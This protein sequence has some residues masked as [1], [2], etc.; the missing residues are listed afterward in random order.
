MNRPLPIFFSMNFRIKQ[1]YVS[2]TWHFL[3]LITFMLSLRSE[4]VLYAVL[5]SLFH[6]IGHLASMI[7]LGNAP[8]SVSF[9]LTGINIKR[10]QEVNVSLS[11]E[12]II[13]LAGPFMNLILFL[14]FVLVNFQN[15]SAKALNAASVNL[16]FMTFNLLPVKGLDGGKVLYYS[17]SKFFSYKTANIILMLSSVIFILLMFSY[18]AYVL[19]VTRY[20][21]TMLIIALMLSLSMFS[22][23]EC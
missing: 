7:A 23:E 4:N 20:N 6:E 11:R 21:F 22:K 19:Y 13:A 18:G 14:F 8:Q 2:I 12:I 10:T 17:V 15:G 5:F 16:I 3:A 1:V 9:E